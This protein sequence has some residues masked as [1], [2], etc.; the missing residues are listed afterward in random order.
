VLGAIY[1]IYS[2]FHI[3]RFNVSILRALNIIRKVI[4]ER[5]RERG[6]RE[7]ERDNVEYIIYKFHRY[8]QRKRNLKDRLK[9]N[10]LKKKDISSL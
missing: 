1:W 4:E 8:Y 7:R 3:I 5:G 9:K 2:K 10:R 6:E